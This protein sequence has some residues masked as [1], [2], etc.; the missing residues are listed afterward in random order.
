MDYLFI[1][2]ETSVVENIII[3]DGITE[4]EPP[5][6]YYVELAGESGAGIGWTKNADGSFSAPVEAL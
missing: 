3:W 6:G 4:W 1:N 2:S 5:A